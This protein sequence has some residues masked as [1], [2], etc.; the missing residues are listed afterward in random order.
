MGITCRK[1]V[2]RLAIDMEWRV[3]G[4]REITPDAIRH[5]IADVSGKL[6]IMVHGLCMNDLRWQRSSEAGYCMITAPRPQR[7]WLHRRLPRYNTGSHIARPTVASFRRR[8]RRWSPPGQYRSSRS[9]S[10]PTAWADWSPVAP[11]ATARKHRQRGA[12]VCAKWSSWAPHAGAPLSAAGAGWN[13]C[14]FNATLRCRTTGPATQRGHH[15]SALMAASARKT[16]MAVI[17]SET[18]ESSIHPLPLP[19]DVDCFAIGGTIGREPT[20]EGDCW[21]TALSLASALGSTRTPTGAGLSAVSTQQ[22]FQD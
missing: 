9:P 2:T 17:V 19:T 22:F 3:G 15:R 13:R 8:W 1:A 11:A 16:G 18:N 20:T 10:S 14:L 12:A 21:V 7:A 6:L 4:R 5:S